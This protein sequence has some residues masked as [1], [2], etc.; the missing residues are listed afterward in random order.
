MHRDLKP[1]NVLL[2][3]DGS[4][5]LADFGLARPVQPNSAAQLTATGAVMGTLAYMAPD[6]SAASPP[7]PAPIS[8]PLA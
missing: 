2:R 1:A 6:S 4:P 5:V 8:M 7:T 3:A